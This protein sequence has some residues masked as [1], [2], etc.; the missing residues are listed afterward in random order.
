MSHQLHRINLGRITY[1]KNSSASVSNVSNQT[2][3]YKLA[4]DS[5]GIV[6]PNTVF[7]SVLAAATALR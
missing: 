4:D 3:N 1:F 5:V 2:T 6:Q 7:A